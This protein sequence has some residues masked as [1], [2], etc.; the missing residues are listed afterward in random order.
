M[1]AVPASA[2]ADA[3]GEAG[4]GERGAARQRLSAA[5]E[6]E[7]ARIGRIRA[8]LQQIADADLAEAPVRLAFETGTEGDRRRRYV[9]S[10]ERLINRRI[11]TFLKVR[12]ASGSGELDLI[13]LQQ[14]MG[15]DKFRDLLADAGILTRPDPV[16]ESTDIATTAAV[17]E[18][19]SNEGSARL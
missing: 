9:L 8:R 14:S 17:V 10:F 18:F 3:F 13:E 11:D 4:T 1:R 2:G 12:K 15:A 6:E 5:V 19:E 16:L 7:L